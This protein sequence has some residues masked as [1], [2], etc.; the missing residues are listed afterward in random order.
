MAR[1]PAVLLPVEFSTTAN[2]FPIT[3]PVAFGQETID[4]SQTLTAST[5][6]T[7]GRVVY[8]E[9]SLS[10]GASAS[11]AVDRL[12][13]AESAAEVT[14]GLE[15]AFG[16]DTFADNST[17]VSANVSGAYVTHTPSSNIAEITIT[18]G[19]DSGAVIYTQ[20]DADSLAI[21]CQQSTEAYGELFVSSSTGVEANKD[22]DLFHVANTDSNLPVVADPFSSL[23]LWAGA[24]A[25]LAVDSLAVQVMNL[26]ANANSEQLIV[27]VTRTTRGQVTAYI[28]SV[29]DFTASEY[30]S[31][32][33]TAV[34]NGSETISV[35]ID[36]AI[37]SHVFGNTTR[38]IAAAVSAR[39]NALF[40]ANSHLY[41]ADE[42][43]SFLSLHQNISSSTLLEFI[44][45]AI[46]SK[47]LFTIVVTPYDKLAAVQASPRTVTVP[48]Y[49]RSV[50]VGALTQS[51]SASVAASPRGAA[52]PSSSRTVSIYSIVQSRS[53]SVPAVVNTANT[54]LA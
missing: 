26:L 28:S 11:T 7:I 22:F 8:A 31:E 12:V 4:N 5:T 51:G 46:A 53:A 29:T 1:F 21:E 17:E 50:V 36:S 42:A 34:A 44:K 3:L 32:I 18:A 33:N 13:T 38:S 41:V 15:Q 20:L 24:E 48:V 23:Q 43:D 45:A 35:Q 27:S 49:G 54:G 14:A 16:R 19:L 10:V 6:S 2:S 47:P 40:A 30:S 25:N 9:S 39:L 52:V 37:T